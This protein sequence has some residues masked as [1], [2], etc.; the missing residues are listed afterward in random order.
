MMKHHAIASALM[1]AYILIAPACTTPGKATPADELPMQAARLDIAVDDQT[2]TI[3]LIG[4]PSETENNFKTPA[5]GLPAALS[6]RYDKILSMHAQPCDADLGGMNPAYL[7]VYAWTG[8]RHDDTYFIRFNPSI[9]DAN[10]ICRINATTR[11]G[12]WSI[13]TFAGELCEGEARFIFPLPPLPHSD[14]NQ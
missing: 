3:Y 13:E 1:L 11:A 5:R 9:S 7:M 4:W 12:T 8:A 14:E 10:L 6:A 2:Y